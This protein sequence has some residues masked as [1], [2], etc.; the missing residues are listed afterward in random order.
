MHGIV[1]GIADLVIAE[2]I[3]QLIGLVVPENR[4][5]GHARGGVGRHEIVCG[6]AQLRIGVAVLIGNNRVDKV[7]GLDVV[8]EVALV[9]D[10]GLRPVAVEG[11]HGGV[12]GIGHGQAQLVLVAVEIDLIALAVNRGDIALVGLDDLIV[13]VVVQQIEVVR[14]VHIDGSAV[15]NVQVVEHHIAFDKVAVFK[16]LVEIGLGGVGELEVNGDGRGLAGGQRQQAVDRLKLAALGLHGVGRGEVLALFQNVGGQG[17]QIKRLLARVVLVVVVDIVIQQ[18]GGGQIVAFAFALVD[19]RHVEGIAAG[20]LD[21]VAQLLERVGDVACVEVGLGGVVGVAHA[22]ALLTDGIGIA[23]LVGNKLG[24]AEQKRS[25]ALG[26]LGLGQAQPFGIFTLLADI[27]QELEHGGNR[28]GHIRGGHGGAGHDL[29]L[30]IAVLAGRVDV[31]ADGGDR[32]VDR[33]ARGRAP[34]GEVAH[35]ERVVVDDVLLLGGRLDDLALGVHEIAERGKRERDGR[36]DEVVD[37]HVDH[38]GLIVDDDH[39]DRAGGSRVGDLILEVQLT[40]LHDRDL[41]LDVDLRVLFGRADADVDLLLAGAVG[42]DDIVRVLIAEGGLP[43]GVIGGV[44]VAVVIAVDG[45]DIGRVCEVLHGG[46]GEV[47]V[48]AGRR[49]GDAIVLIIRADVAEGGVLRH[50][51]LVAVCDADDDTRALK[52]LIDVAEDGVFQLGV[53]GEAVLRADGHVDDVRAEAVGVLQSVEVHVGGGAGLAFAVIEDL[54][55]EDLRTGGRAEEGVFFR[56][57]VI[58]TAGGNTRNVRAVTLTIGDV[59]VLIG[60]V[61]SKGNLCVD[62]L[63][64]GARVDEVFL[65][66]AAVLG[67]VAVGIRERL[68]REVQAGVEDG[69]DLARAVN[70]EF[71]VS[72]ID[73]GDPV[74]IIHLRGLFAL[75]GLGDGIGVGDVDRIDAVDRGDLVEVA[76]GDVAAEAVDEVG[77]VILQGVVD[78]GHFRADRLMLVDK[79]AAIGDRALVA[80][81]GN[82]CGRGGLQNDDRANHIAV[83]VRIQVVLLEGGGLEALRLNILD[84]GVEILADICRSCLARRGSRSVSRSGGSACY[85]RK[86]HDKSQKHCKNTFEFSHGFFSFFN[87]FA[88]KKYRII[89]IG[90]LSQ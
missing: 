48:I 35:Q 6:V 86:Q 24:G 51:I 56:F 70:A 89:L 81:L 20:L 75:D 74:R 61:I 16:Q 33:Q 25:C 57:L 44:G 47:A 66:Q 54:H 71:V 26:L 78:A 5:V 76:V 58:S 65:G 38:T 36:N 11:Q 1:I 21:V 82:V 8:G 32:R 69:N 43:E 42:H 84:R 88:G 39:A 87:S 85:A 17:V 10:V 67:A 23:V 41:A 29:V 68:M 64:G 37:G 30:V 46:D 9:E 52:A 45:H 3:A 72:G 14:I 19:Q 63:A 31:A 7:V 18:V 80:A 34:A 4:S 77:E 90:I 59:V 27:I 62:V 79:S 40:A 55:R 60:V 22:S 73:A 28:A 15:H 50:G 2:V 49:S 83:L 12:E 53:I 13:A